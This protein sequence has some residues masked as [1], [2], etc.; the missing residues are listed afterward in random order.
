MSYDLALPF[1]KNRGVQAV[2]STDLLGLN[3][4]LTLTVISCTLFRTITGGV[5]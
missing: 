1:T 4:I 2:S 3:F 5:K